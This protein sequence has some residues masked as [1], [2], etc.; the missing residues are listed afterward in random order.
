MQ[1]LSH[2]ADCEVFL[3]FDEFCAP[4]LDEAL[5][6]A[7][8]SEA[9]SVLVVTPTMTQGGAHSE[10]DIPAAISRARERHPGKRIVY[11]WPFPVGDV[12]AFLAG[13]ARQYLTPDHT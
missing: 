7:T 5:D 4:S 12:A 2:A 9:D 8:A 1:E 11:A 6:R 10:R 13:Q 3:G